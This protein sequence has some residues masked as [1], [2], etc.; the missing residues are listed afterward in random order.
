MAQTRTREVVTADL[1]AEGRDALLAGDKPRAQALF[2]AVLRTEPEHVEAWLWLGGAHSEQA[3]IERCLRRALELD[4]DNQQALDGLAWLASRQPSQPSAPRAAT[5]PEPAS[6]PRIRPRKDFPAPRPAPTPAL[7]PAEVGLRRDSSALVEA[8]V[9][10]MGVG[11]LLGLLRLAGSLRPATLLLLRSPAR[12]LGLAPAITIAVV[13]A[14]LHALVLLLVWALLSRNVSR[15][16]N[17]RRGDHFDSL[18]RTAEIFAPGYLAS[19]ALV[20][21]FGAMAWSERRW[22]PAALLIWLILVASAAL[23]GRRGRQLFAALRLPI[24]RRAVNIG[25]IVVPALLLAIAGFGLAG[26]VVRA[27]LAAL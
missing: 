7:A 6:A 22:M 15:A 12:P 10:V 2:K 26:S 9:H 19:V 16:R 4:P 24:T 21:T 20:V 1:L 5:L 11:A 13:A 18:L 23:V 14:L 17:D 27:M 8:A 25:R 3:E